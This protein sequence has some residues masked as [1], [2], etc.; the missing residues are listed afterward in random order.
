[1]ERSTITLSVPSRGEPL[2]FSRKRA[3]FLCWLRSPQEMPS[4]AR[5]ARRSSSFSGSGGSC[6]RARIFT[7]RV[8]SSFATA[9][10][11]A[12]MHSSTSWCDSS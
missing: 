10:F 9:S 4:F 8:H 6:R 12:T 2:I 5:F 3:R 7:P 11:A 1:M